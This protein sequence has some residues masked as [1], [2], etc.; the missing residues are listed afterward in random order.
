MEGGR[1]KVEGGRWKVEGVRR[2][3]YG[4]RRTMSKRNLL[5]IGEEIHKGVALSQ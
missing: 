5:F 2:K 4:S 1:W 3:A